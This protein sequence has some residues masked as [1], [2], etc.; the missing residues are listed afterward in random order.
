MDFAETFGQVLK[1]H[2][3]A[4]GYSQEEL[5]HRTDMHSTTVSLYE[6]GLRKPT[7]HSVFILA[8]ALEIQP[9]VLVAEFESMDPEI[10]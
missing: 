10:D 7:L 3:K 8:R 1:A 4:A 6:R 2:R 5:A 9:S